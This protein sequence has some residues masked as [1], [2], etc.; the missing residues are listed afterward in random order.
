[1]SVQAMQ[2]SS[3]KDSFHNGIIYIYVN[4]EQF[5]T[6]SQILEAQQGQQH[7]SR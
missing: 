1:M 4:N 2:L 3:S 6:G 7:S 5:K